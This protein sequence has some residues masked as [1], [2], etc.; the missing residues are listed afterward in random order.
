[1]TVWVKYSQPSSQYSRLQL[2]GWKHHHDDWNLDHSRFRSIEQQWRPH[3]IDRF[4]SH[5]NTHLPRFNSRFWN[6]GIEAVDAFTCDWSND[7]NWLWLQYYLVPRVIR[8]G[9]NCR[10]R[11]ILV[12]P[13]WPSEGFGQFCFHMQANQ[14]HLSKMCLLLNYINF[15]TVRV[16]LLKFGFWLH[17]LF[18]EGWGIRSCL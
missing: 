14:L 17:I 13:E 6:P 11:G 12:V 9:S 2:N 4:A 16:C 18:L 10:A 8:H 3:T 5:Y 7:N 1:M 15:V